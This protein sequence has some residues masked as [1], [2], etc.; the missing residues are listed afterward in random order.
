MT[1]RARSLAATTFALGMIFF[2]AALGHAARI[3]PR[4]AHVL[5][6]SQGQEVHLVWVFLTDKGSGNTAPYVSG[7]SAARRALRGKPS[8]I[9]ADLPI[10]ETYVDRLRPHVTAVRQ[11]SRWFNAVSVEA[12]PEQ[13]AAIARLPMVQTLDVVTRAARATIGAVEAAASGPVAAPRTSALDYGLSFQQLQRIHVPALHDR[14]L[15]GAGIFVAHFDNG[16]RLLSH[17]VFSTTRIVATRDFI[18]GDVNPAPPATAPSSWGEHGISTLSVIAGKFPGKLIGAAFGADFALARTEDDGSETPFEE[19]NWVAAM[20]WAD[21]LGVDVI[22]SSVGY[23]DYESPHMSWTWQQLDGNTTVITRAADLAVARGIVVVNAAGNSG[24]NSLHNTLLAPADGDSVLTIGGVQPD[25]QLY[26]SSS[27]GPT[28]SNPP[29]IKP[30]VLAQG[31]AVYLAGSGNTM[32]YGYN[33]GTSFACPMAAGV[34]ALLL[35]AKPEATP[36]EIA[37]ALRA[38]A[39]RAA[40]PDNSYGWGIVNAELALARL[41]T[42]VE[43]ASMSRLKGLYR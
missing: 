27:V 1:T 22:S 3:E 16:Y 34:V 18:D 2:L 41:T 31:T 23:L 33:S 25:G 36:V 15:S 35:E 9:T 13:I 20:E 11:R 26:F 5:A 4:L 39:S 42:A 17:E 24:F 29:R 32:H 40:T 38:T 19:D 10:M 7:R 8:P 14:G 21:S 37:A 28:T 12:T 43:P 6:N 30:D